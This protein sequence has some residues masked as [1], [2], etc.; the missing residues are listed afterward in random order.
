M[1]KTEEDRMWVEVISLIIANIPVQYL[2]D[3]NMHIYK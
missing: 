2:K 3:G 1:V